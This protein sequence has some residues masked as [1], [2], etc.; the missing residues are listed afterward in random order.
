[1]A[2]QS[3]FKQIG[4]KIAAAP[5]LSQGMALEIIH[6]SSRQ[7]HIDALGTG[8]IGNSGSRGNRH[9][10]LELLLQLQHKIIKDRHDSECMQHPYH[11][12]CVPKERI[13]EIQC[14]SLNL[15][16]FF[17]RCHASPAAEAC[18]RQ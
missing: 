2:T 18:S 3:L 9:I 15:T 14:L 11:H 4:G 16:G 10:I 6:D 1:M 12:T 13:R 7:G 5:A 17:L 8:G